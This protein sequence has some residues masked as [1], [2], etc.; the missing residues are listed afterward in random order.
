MN[1]QVELSV[2]AIPMFVSRDTYRLL[3]QEGAK[4]GQTGPEFLAEKL[5][6]IVELIRKKRGKND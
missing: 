3:T 5:Q 1:N 6:E 2:I 4:N